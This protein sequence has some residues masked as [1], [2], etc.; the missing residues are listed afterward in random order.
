M[1]GRRA[2]MRRNGVTRPPL[3]RKRT[4]SFRDVRLVLVPEMFQ[5][6]QHR[7][8]RG[9]AEGT[10]GLAGD[11]PRNAREKIEV[12]HLPFSA[13]DFSE[14]LVQPVG[15]FA[16]RRAFAARLVTV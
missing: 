6:R 2:L 9:V 15:A 10:E 3:C 12:A 4:A 7:R 14:N 5:R 11:I 1:L 8:D 13:L 16:A